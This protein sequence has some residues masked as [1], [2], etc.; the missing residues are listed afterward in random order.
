VLASIGLDHSI[1][2]AGKLRGWNL[3]RS[4]KVFQGTMVAIAIMLSAVV[5]GSKLLGVGAS[6][7]W[8]QENRLYQQVDD[9]LQDEGVDSADVVM[10][11]NP[12]G[13]YLE[14]G[15]PSIA[16]PDGDAVTLMEVARKYNARY[17]VLEQGSTP[18]GLVVLFDL[19]DQFPGL[20]YLGDVNGA[21]I[22]L[23]Q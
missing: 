5:F 2:W 16:V 1:S 19:P 13:F 6:E 7:R 23:I 9:F 8:G 22:F 4:K 12:P 18:A 17:V 3:P 14:S 15:N 21:R 11:A 10:V 20:V